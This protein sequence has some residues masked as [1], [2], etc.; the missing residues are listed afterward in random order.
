VA[1]TLYCYRH[2][3]RETMVSCSEC[4]RGICTDCMVFAP[5]G[6]RCPDHSGQAQG[7]QR[8]TQGLR[9]A[10]FEGTGA[11]VT[12]ILIA[13]NVGV[14]LLELAAG[15]ELNG[16]GNEI[17]VK[18]VLFGPFVAAGDWWRLFT[19]MF[20][21]YGPIHLAFNMLG[22]WWFGAA[23]EQVLGR[24]RFLLLYIV[25]GLA[26]SAGA[27]IFSPESPT[28]GA[29]GALFGILGA[30][31]VLER[32]RTYVFG[33]GALGIIALNLV[34]TFA[35]PGISIGGHLGGLIGG[36][37][38]MLALS[39]LGRTHA[40][41]GRPGIVGIVGLVAIGIASILVA[42]WRVAPLA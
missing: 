6:I 38:G 31:L 27:L 37:A 39:R 17:Y 19:S 12:K 16:T 10:S 22:L 13:L 1:E 2:P 40:V 5:V 14:Y 20:L 36:A 32:Q 7:T 3:D 29:S 30:A 4:G 42:Y 35:I 34:F 24:G 9:R 11:I 21:H 33:G 26:G 23:V 25:S 8:V 15:G 41:Y 28:V 18:G